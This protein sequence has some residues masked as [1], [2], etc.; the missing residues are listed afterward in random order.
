LKKTLASRDIQIKQLQ[1]LCESL[2]QQV[3]S[4]QQLTEQLA[5]CEG[6]ISDLEARLMQ[7]EAEGARELQ[8]Q[9]DVELELK[10][11]LE[12]ALKNYEM[13]TDECNSIIANSVNKSLY[14]DAMEAN[15]S[16]KEE[17]AEAKRDIETGVCLFHLIHTT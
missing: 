1:D 3:A 17:L 13:K 8:K 10:K 2:K 7:T 4:K 11:S 14:N 9:K 12:N 6:Q 5:R 16:L 15:K